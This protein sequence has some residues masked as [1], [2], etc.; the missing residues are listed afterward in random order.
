MTKKFL[1]VLAAF[2]CFALLPVTAWASQV[3]ITNLSTVGEIKEK[4]EDAIKD[5]GDGGTVIVTGE[6]NDAG[7]TL[8]LRI[9]AN[10]TVEWRA[11]Y[12]GS[13][14][15]GTRRL[16]ELLN[17]D[18]DSGVGIFELRGTVE[19]RA[20]N[21]IYLT[22][23]EEDPDPDTE[24][25]FHE[26]DF[27]QDKNDEKTAPEVANTDLVTVKVIGGKVRAAAEA[28]NPTGTL[29]GILFYGNGRLTMENGTVEAKG[30]NE[31]I[32][33]I[34]MLRGKAEIINSTV[35]ANGLTIDDNE[36][37]LI[38]AI[39]VTYR[40][41]DN[42]INVTGGKIS[43]ASVIGRNSAIRFSNGKLTLTDSIVEAKSNSMRKG[44]IA[45]AIFIRTAGTVAVR[46]N[47][48]VSAFNEQDEVIAAYGIYAQA[49]GKVAV[50]GGLV[51]A[52]SK[53]KTEPI[54]PP[55]NVS[56]IFIDNPPPGVAAY[57]KGAC[58]GELTV[59]NPT[60]AMIVEVDTPVIPPSRHGTSEGLTVN[61]PDPQ[62]PGETA[63]WDTTGNIPKI[64]FTLETLDEKVELEW[65]VKAADPI[66]PSDPE[67]PG[68]PSD[69]C[70]N[71]GAGT[72]YAGLF[73]A[74][75]YALDRRFNAA[76]C[77]RK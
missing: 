50:T 67:I 55:A 5:L 19:N 53:Q 61:K 58:V 39:Y 30:N 41:E 28:P 42:D 25:F 74:L 66:N 8:E 27:D 13:Y 20:G 45:N 29:Y 33:A 17:G 64:V 76:R 72:I 47:S 9:P 44:D 2:L 57:L 3:D 63:V 68:N 40:H 11:D 4:I 59:S 15:Q 7:E 34:G 10:V 12:S 62:N 70:G 77:R 73:I 65:G 48:R 21:A 35:T 22:K 43:S 60:G 71:T 49:T 31:Y 52:V 32:S 16:I 46:G 23:D 18:N 75:L 6:K 69:G 56:A 1:M 14:D 38:Y 26:G 54:D 51:E 24:I 37:R 36:P